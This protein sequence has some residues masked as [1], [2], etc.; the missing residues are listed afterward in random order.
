MKN[1]EIET[2]MK[3]RDALEER[4]K[5]EKLK[6]FE[7]FTLEF[8]AYFE[9]DMNDLPSTKKGC[10]EFIKKLVDGGNKVV[11]DSKREGLQGTQGPYYTKDE[12]FGE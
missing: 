3:R 11:D 1:N 10:R 12:T 5:D 7:N 9:K 8:L 6:L 2:L 4:I